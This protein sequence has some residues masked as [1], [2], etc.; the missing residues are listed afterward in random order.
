[1]TTY[2]IKTVGEL[3]REKLASTAPRVDQEIMNIG[4]DLDDEQGQQKQASPQTQ[5]TEPVD[6]GVEGQELLKIAANVDYVATFL[7][8]ISEGEFESAQGPGRGAGTIDMQT[9]TSQAGIPVNGGSQEHKTPDKPQMEAGGAPKENP[10]TVFK[11]DY[12]DPAGVGEGMGPVGAD[13]STLTSADTAVK[14]TSSLERKKKEAEW[15]A[16]VYEAILAKM[17][18]EAAGGGFQESTTGPGKGPGTPETDQKQDPPIP[19]EG[20]VVQDTQKVIDVTQRET[21]APVKQELKDFVNEPALSKKTDPVASDMFDHAEDAGVKVSSAEDAL[22]RVF[23]KKVAARGCTCGGAGTCGYCSYIK[24]MQ[25]L[26]E[27]TAAADP[28]PAINY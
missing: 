28:K 14:K 2:K 8:K 12:T 26:S 11:T 27:N 22:R 19:P 13:G 23:L 18:Q 10:D 17:G 9:P 15:K 6:P 20:K 5:T 25:K 7:Q 4:R 3:V 1:M 16:K 21:K 24:G